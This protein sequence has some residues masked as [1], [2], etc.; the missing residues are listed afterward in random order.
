MRIEK[1]QPFFGKLPRQIFLSIVQI[2]VGKIIVRVGGVRIS[3]EVE[4]EDFDR[5]LYLARAQM[6]RADDVDGNFR[7][8]L[9]LGI[10]STGFHQLLR[11][12]GDSA[13]Q[14]DLI[15]DRGACPGVL[16]SV[17]TNQS[18]MM[19]GSSGWILNM[20]VPWPPLAGTLLMSLVSYHI[21][22][23]S[24]AAE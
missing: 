13:G 11:H 1:R 7:P 19:P 6:V 21:Q 23:A 5:F 4:L 2:G 24:C 15:E 9:H 12:L 22:G 3:E 8:Q 10:F 17:V 14:P 20:S 18:T 16:I